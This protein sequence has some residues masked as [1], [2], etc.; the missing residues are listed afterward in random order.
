MVF[1]SIAKEHVGVFQGSEP[2]P[3]QPELSPV[4][5]DAVPSEDVELSI[6]H[7]KLKESRDIEEQ[8]KLVQ[9]IKAIEWVS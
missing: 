4:P 9:E 7:H 6:L 2:A 1:Q 5:L 3:P 8:A